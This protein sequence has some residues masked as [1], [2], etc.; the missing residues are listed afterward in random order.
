MAPLNQALQPRV[1]VGV[2]QTPPPLQR[3]QKMKP[4]CGHVALSR[5][6]ATQISVLFQLAIA[7]RCKWVQPA[8]QMQRTFSRVAYPKKRGP[9]NAK[10]NAVWTA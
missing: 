1:A 2:L 10:C 4:R 7:A 3:G 6:N 5:E 9:C 8:T